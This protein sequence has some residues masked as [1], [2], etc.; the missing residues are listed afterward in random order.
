MAGHHDAMRVF[1]PAQVAC[2]LAG[3]VPPVSCALTIGAK[4]IACVRRLGT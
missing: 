2:S 1:E 3:E 4:V